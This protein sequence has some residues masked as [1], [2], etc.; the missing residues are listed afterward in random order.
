MKSLSVVILAIFVCSAAFSQDMNAKVQDEKSNTEI[1]L[2]YCNRAGLMAGE[3]GSFYSAEWNAYRPDNDV[4]NNLKYKLDD[5]NF[6]IVLGTWC[7]DSKEQVPRFVKLLDCLKYDVERVTF[8]AVDRTK[9][10]GSVSVADMKI[11]KVPTIIAY[12]DGKEIGRIIETPVV[13]MEKDLLDII[14]K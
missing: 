12:K 11:E 14:S 10:A 1:L 13:S 3:F 2:G 5:I 9:T 7:G 6:T 4:L 8:I